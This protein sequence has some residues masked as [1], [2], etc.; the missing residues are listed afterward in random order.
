MERKKKSVEKSQ[1][2]TYRVLMTIEPAVII[3]KPQTIRLDQG[4]LIFADILHP[5]SKSPKG[6]SISATLP[7]ADIDTAMSQARGI[8]NIILALFS[9]LTKTSIPELLIM[10]A[11]DVT[12]GKRSGKF[13]QYYYDLP[14]TTGSVRAVDKR[15]LSRSSEVITGLKESDNNRVTRAMHWFRL[16]TKS[17]DLLERFTS[18][19][20][21]LETI[22][23]TLCHYYGIEVEYSTCDCC[24][25]NVPILSGV[26]K[27]FQ[28]IGDD[29]LT[30]KKTSG[31][32]AITIHGSQPLQVIVPQLKE[33][34]RSLENAL[35][36][37]LNLIL[38]LEGSKDNTMNIGNTHEAKYISTATVEGQD[39]QFIDK[40]I[41]PAFEHK[42]GIVYPKSGGQF[43]RFE[44]RPVID[45]N[46]RFNE[47]EHV[48]YTQPHLAHRITAPLEEDYEGFSHF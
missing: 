43:F 33:K 18:L 19:W 7:A 31:L 42:I 17:K 39:L 14:F 47:E 11:Y 20:I 12:P 23:L 3:G 26:K 46:F 44:Q 27:L 10:K 24:G 34:I 32:R 48:L 28:D 41:I 5:K 13:I 2:T 36:G 37:G 30:W 21:G 22:N 45:K 6:M 15:A 9:V 35:Y 8:T 40:E 16:A 38:G 4:A 29:N 1:N 25:K